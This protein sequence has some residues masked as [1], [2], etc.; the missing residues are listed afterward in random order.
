MKD[1]FII[2]AIEDKVACTKQ[3][4]LGWQFEKIEGE[5]WQ[6]GTIVTLLDGLRER[7]ISF[8]T[9]DAYLVVSEKLTRQLPDATKTL[10]NLGCEAV[11]V[12]CWENL[13]RKA[14]TCAEVTTDYTDEVQVL[15]KLCP[16]VENTFLFV[17]HTIDLQRKSALIAIESDIERLRQEAMQLVQ[18]KAQLQIQIDALQRLDL[19]HL[20]TYMPLF[21]EKFFSKVA[22]EDLA[23]MSGNLP[24]IVLSSSYTEPDNATMQHLKR[25][26]NALSEPLRAQI[27]R[28][29]QE[30]PQR[31][32]L[33][34]RSSMQDLIEG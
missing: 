28:F 6:D 22:L 29:A 12:L 13:I 7:D 15:T 23:L 3:S 30:M 31:H 33:V 20:V 25:K 14:Q 21:F 1:P 4:E 9:I 18:E 11:Q 24:T 5:S 10:V 19:A 27:V 26:F 17:D 2:F 32:Q 16:L 8:A 34:V